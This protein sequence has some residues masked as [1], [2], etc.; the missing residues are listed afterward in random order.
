MGGQQRGMGSSSFGGNQNSGGFGSNMGGSPMGGGMNSSS[1]MGNSMGGR[2]GGMGQSQNS[3]M[4]Q[5]QR[6][7]NM[8]GG[9]MQNGMQQQGNNMGGGGMQRQDINGGQMGMNTMGSRQNNGPISY[10][11]YQDDSGA[12]EQRLRSY[13]PADV[14]TY[15]YAN[16]YAYD[17]SQPL[18]GQQYYSRGGTSEDFRDQSSR[19]SPGR[20]GPPRDFDSYSRRSNNGIGGVMDDNVRD[21][22]F[23]SYRMSNDYGREATRSSFE[24]V[25]SS[26]DFR[27]TVSSNVS[28]REGYRREYD[29]DYRGTGGYNGGYSGYDENSGQQYRMQDFL[30]PR[31]REIRQR[32]LDREK[33]FNLSQEFGYERNERRDREL[34]KRDEDRRAKYEFRRDREREQ[35][36]QFNDVRSSPYNNGRDIDDFRQGP[37]RFY[38]S[39]TPRER[40]RG[41]GNTQMRNDR[42]SSGRGPD[43]FNR[44][45]GARERRGGQDDLYQRDGMYDRYNDQSFG[46]RGDDRRSRIG[47]GRGYDRRDSNYNDDRYDDGRGRYYDDGYGNNGYRKESSVWDGVKD[48]VDPN[49][50]FDRSMDGVKN[51]LGLN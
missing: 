41:F 36:R 1:G 44:Y 18:F 28:G 30:T 42:R 39:G 12:R 46:R 21:S 17:S 22:Q 10:G 32:E 27:R 16:S 37:D 23:Q 25:G 5:Q 43:N 31:E 24:R 3:M 8:G 33:N 48:M 14:D 15:G 11:S 9:G 40:E 29:S 26:E 7:N 34:R 51:L 13:R 35:Y 49:R 6:G 45:D 2:S 20:N 4:G 50:N 38:N 47:N 19:F